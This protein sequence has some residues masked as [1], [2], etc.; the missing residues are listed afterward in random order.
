MACKCEM[1]KLNAA[2]KQQ[3]QLSSSCS[4]SSSSSL[5]LNTTSSTT[6]ST[7]SCSA[8]S[9]SSSS[10]GVINKAGK[11]CSCCNRPSGCVCH[12]NS[13]KAYLIGCPCCSEVA[14]SS[15]M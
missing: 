13:A 12:P 7:Q 10:H 4:G 14:Q 5:S 8:F 1:K 11:G 15:R 6:L 9:S 2:S 3:Q